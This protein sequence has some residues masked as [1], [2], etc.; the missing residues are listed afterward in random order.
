MDTPERDILWMVKSGEGPWLS[1]TKE[2]WVRI[3]RQA[4][5]YNTMGKPDEPGT[6]SFNGNGHHGTQVSVEHFSD[7]TYI[8][9]PELHDAIVEALKARILD[10]SNA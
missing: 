2:Q 10:P 5:F 9:D 8:H 6:A 1:V 3:E 4:G 7:D